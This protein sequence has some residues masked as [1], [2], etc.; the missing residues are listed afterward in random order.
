MSTGTG[1]MCCIVH[2][3]RRHFAKRERTARRRLGGWAFSNGFSIVR[4]LLVLLRVI[5]GDP[6][7]YY[8]AAEASD[9]D[10]AG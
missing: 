2:R 10:L 5:I 6:R 8:D 1:V 4:T 9:R 3:I 7:R